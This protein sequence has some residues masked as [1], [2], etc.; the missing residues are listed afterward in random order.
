MALRSVDPAAATFL[1]RVLAG[2]NLA[3]ALDAAGQ[4]F[5]F[6]RWLVQAL[7]ERS[8]LGLSVEAGVSM[9]DDA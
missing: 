8:L 2:D 9:A 4:A 6:E 5:D 3:A 7:Q 1:R